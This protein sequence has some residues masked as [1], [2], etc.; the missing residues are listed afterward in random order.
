MTTYFVTAPLW[1]FYLR[2]Q[3]FAD[4]INENGGAA[5][6]FETDIPVC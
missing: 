1:V 2:Y 5:A 3:E 6:P 4:T